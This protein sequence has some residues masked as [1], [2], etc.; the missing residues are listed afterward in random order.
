MVRKKLKAIL[1]LLVA[2]MFVLQAAPMYSFAEESAKDAGTVTAEQQSES[3]RRKLLTMKMRVLLNYAIDENG[4]KVELTEDAD[5]G[6]D[7][8]IA[9]TSA[10]ESDSLYQS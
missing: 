3:R 4:N 10:P 2:V 9:A 6:A 7:E 8:D 5:T 1:A